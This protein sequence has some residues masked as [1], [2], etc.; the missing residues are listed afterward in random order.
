MLLP[1]SEHRNFI[2]TLKLM[3]Q[4]PKIKKESVKYCTDNVKCSQLIFDH[5][6]VKPAKKEDFTSNHRPPVP[7]LVH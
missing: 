3:L 7:L 1:P 6:I 4:N 2:E 5:T